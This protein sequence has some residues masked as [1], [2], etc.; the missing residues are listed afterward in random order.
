MRLTT[1]LQ[2]FL[3]VALCAVPIASDAQ[4]RRSFRD[5]EP[6]IPPPNI[7][8]YKP[9]STLVVP[10]HEVPRARFPLVD[11]HGHPP[12]LDNLETIESVVA[13]M[14]RLNIGVMVQARP[15]SGRTLRSQIEAVREAGYEDR[16]VFFASLDLEN[17]DLGSG[18]KIARQLEEDIDAGAVGIG[19]ISKAFG[20]FHTKM[21]GS[22]LAMDD[23]ELD[24]VWETAARLNIPVFVHTADPPEF[25]ETLDFTNERWLELAIFENRRFMDRDRF[26][27]FDELME[28]RNRMLM[29]HPNTTWILAHMGWH[30]ADLARL[31]EIFDAH[32]NVLGEI[33]AVLYDLGRQ[34]RFAASFFAKYK[35]RIL[36]GKDSF[37][38]DEYPYFFRV[39]ETADEYFDYYRDYHAFWKLYGMDLPDEVLRALYYENAQR[40]I[41]GL[42]TATLPGV[43]P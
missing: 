12:A 29:K 42:P 13:E 26:P 19:E 1:R 15:S 5:R 43:I 37:Q 10:E 25:F 36:F 27:S 30:T 17:I 39:L 24:I 21:D 35:D 20:L 41:P 22:R 28:E 9:Q 7:T 8:E 34:P 4:Q 6:T 32:P 18:L 38:P 33:G 3:F 23:P 2:V 11:I 14:D 40:I 16:F 31:G